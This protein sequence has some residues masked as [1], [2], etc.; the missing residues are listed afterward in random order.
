[1]QQNKAN[2]EK[3]EKGVQETQVTP[4]VAPVTGSLH[5]F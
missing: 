1:M 4:Y 3:Q 5:H 2:K